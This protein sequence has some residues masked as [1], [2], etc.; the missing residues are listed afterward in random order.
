VVVS[1]VSQITRCT[2]AAGLLL[3]PSLV[4]A[5][6]TGRTQ[7]VELQ[8]GPLKAAPTRDS[9]SAISLRGRLLA[10]YDFVVWTATNSVV[11]RHPVPGSVE[12]SVAR[13]IDE[14][15]VVAFGRPSADRDTFFV[16]YEVMQREDDPDDYSVVA[17][18]PARADTGYYARATR[19]IAISRAD[20]GK[21]ARPYDAAVLE[22]ADH[23][24]WVY[25]MP[26]QVKA[27][28]YPLGADARY[29]VQADGR[30]IIAKRLLHTTLIEFAPAI[31]G[32]GKIQA[33]THTAALDDIP[34]DTD[35]YHVLTREPKVPEYVVTDEFL[36]AV[37][38]TGEIRLVGRTRD[39]LGRE[40]A[41]E[42]LPR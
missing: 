4:P 8:G 31:A 17:F 23:T 37:Y 1:V 24:L 9:L 7:S 32:A 26:A 33:S 6:A 14:H 11:A 36:Y 40:A 41:K 2:V 39:V 38:P 34:E 22:R 19:A 29:L 12:S 18:S 28:V 3:V 5:Q 16:A 21:P 25:L 13:R 35:V 27:D 42:R 20:F 10:E 15:W 30:A